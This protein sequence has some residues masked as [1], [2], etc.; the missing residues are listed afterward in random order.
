MTRQRATVPGRELVC[1]IGRPDRR[2]VFLSVRV[3]LCG[4]VD[5]LAARLST[6]ESAMAVRVLYDPT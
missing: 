2:G 6:A 5:L 4:E 3:V 1:A